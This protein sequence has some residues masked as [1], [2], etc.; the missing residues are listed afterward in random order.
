M[1]GKKITELSS[2]SL[3]NLPLSGVTT[4]IYSGITHQHNLSHLR[5]ILVDSGSHYFTGSQVINGN[6][7]ISG[8][9]TAQEYILSSSI[10]NITTET[11][12]GSSNFGNSLDDN[13]NFTGSLKIS[14][15]LLINETSFTAATSGTSGTNG[16][17]GSSGSSGTSGTSGSDG[18]S[19]TSGESGTSGSSGTSGES[20][21]S[22]SS[23]TSGVNGTNGSSGTSG[24]SGVN[25]TNG[26]SG[27]SGSSGSNGSS[28]TSGSNGSSGTSGSNGSSGTSGG[29]GSSG[30]SGLNGSSGTSGTSGASGG[31]GSSGTSGTSGTGVS[32][33]YV[34][35]SRS[36]AQTTG[37]TANGLVVFTQVD[38]STGSDISLNTST[39]QITLAANRTYRLMAQIPTF[40]SSGSNSRPTFSWYNE[41]TS[42]WVGS[43]S[44]IYAPSDGAGY[45]SSMG[46]SEALI[47]TTGT[48]VVSYRI[49]SNSLVTSLGGS[50]DFTTTGS[51]PWFDIQVIS[52]MVP[53]MNGTSGTSGTSGSNGSSGTSGSNGSSGTS[54]SNG[55][56]GTSG[57]VSYTGLI[58]SGSL[59][60]TQTISGSLNVVGNINSTASSGDEGGEIDLALAQTNNN[61]T[62]SINIDVWRNRLRFFEGGGNAR[63]AYLDLT[64]QAAGVGSEILTKASGIVNAG[65]YV[66]LGDL[67]ARIPTSGNRS[68]QVAT[69]SSGVT[70]SV[71][72]SGIYN[73]F[74]SIAGITIQSGSPLSVTSTPTYLN[75]AAGFT[76]S[77]SIDTWN[78]MDTTVGIAWRIS[79]II[80]PSFNSNLITI[81][82]L[83]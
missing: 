36:T 19:G 38:N 44:A 66:I 14:G 20:G 3:S 68:L 23:G 34:R 43:L 7:T 16:S 60:G 9:I 27:T 40:M 75:A 59:G 62:G 24:T 57:V 58:T 28:G 69:I 1:A 81:E 76:Y 11:V 26:Y 30:T 51:Y 55:S 79:C 63:G 5:Q 74:S 37:L 33:S 65:D 53:L 31:T 13:H 12:S 77:G 54:G 2:G 67:K 32:A 78:I 4:I 80:G 17:S 10:T 82:R 45:S 70:Y 22:G 18:S 42:G 6:L 25:G 8:S 35:G 83:Y 52:G 39:G 48:T 41:T 46:M 64:R 21:T 50:S 72:G 29:T 15:S 71:I 61:L 73:Q 56:S 49:I 47:T